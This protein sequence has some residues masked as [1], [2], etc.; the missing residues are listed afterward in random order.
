MALKPCPECKR[1][2]SDRAA[3]CPH[4]GS[5]MAAPKPLQTTEDSALNRNRGCGDI[6]IFGPLLLI[7][8]IFIMILLR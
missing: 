5:P 4:C 1:E 3:A 6:I 8:I 2:V 7:A